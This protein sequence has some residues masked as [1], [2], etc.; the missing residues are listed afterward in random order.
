MRKQTYAD[1]TEPGTE[2][3][4]P[5]VRANG[6]LYRMIRRLIVFILG[7]SVLLVGIVM[8]VAPGPAF[9]VIPLGLAILATEFVWARTILHR[10]KDRLVNS[11]GDQ[12]ESP[13]RRFV[14]WGKHIVGGDQPAQ[15]PPAIH[16]AAGEDRISSTGRDTL[17]SAAPGEH[18][19][20]IGIVHPQTDQRE[21]ERKPQAL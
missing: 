12:K 2:P 18:D 21:Q 6:S 1:T 16:Q 8:I 17:P 19:A 4:Q 11:T 14:A 7:M 9:V 3:A 20:K 13:W 10:L 5:P 15:Q